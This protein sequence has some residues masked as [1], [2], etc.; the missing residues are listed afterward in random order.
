MISYSSRSNCASARQYYYDLLGGGAEGDVP[1]IVLRHVASCRRCQAD[2]SR[3]RA[4]LAD[5]GNTAQSQKDLVISELL[6]LHFAWIGK[7]VTCRTVKA[8]L[9]SLADP[10]LQISIPTP[11]TVHLDNCRACSDDL[12]ILGNLGLTQKQLYRLGQLLA[13]K[14]AEEPVSCSQARTSIPAV[15]S[16]AFQETTA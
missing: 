14:L 13:D 7:S 10:M 3:L 4:L 5:T 9:P 12:L 15:T 6:S 2:I 16:I 1:E 11:V 8:F